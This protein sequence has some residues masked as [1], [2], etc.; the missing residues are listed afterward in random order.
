MMSFNEF[1]YDASVIVMYWWGMTID[2]LFVP[3][4]GLLGSVLGNG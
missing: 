1:V 4:D 2:I 3:V